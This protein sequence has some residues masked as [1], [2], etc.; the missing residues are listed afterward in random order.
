MPQSVTPRAVHAPDRTA[1]E[2]AREPTAA[3]KPSNKQPAYEQTAISAAG[4][5]I[6]GPGTRVEYVDQS[7]RW[8]RKHESYGVLVS[9]GRTCVTWKPG[10]SGRGR[11]LRTPLHEMRV[12]FCGHE[13]ADIDPRH[14]SSYRHWS[15]WTLA[16]HLQFR[17]RGAQPTGEQTAS[18]PQGTPAPAQE[19][20]Q[21]TLFAVEPENAPHGLQE[22][23]TGPLVVIPCSA[24]KLDRPA[25]AGELYTGSYHAA[26]R[27]AADAL[28]A[29]GGTVLIL[30]ARHGLLRL[31]DM[32]APYNTRMGEPGSITAAEL[33]AQARRMGIADADT[34]T[35]LAGAAYAAA[36]QA[37]WP[38]AAT[39]LAGTRG[40]GQQRARLAALARTQ[41]STAA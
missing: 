17:R 1:V 25:P 11:T 27:R 20:E 38:N 12:D 14:P 7:R 34:V 28:T 13:V 37:V 16:E 9:I 29:A 31:D 6:I 10:R 5:G 4:P 8:R 41:F 35:I 26:C 2:P 19:A 24:G 18:S 36:A 40:I 33:R 23:P 30:S 39:P 21:L 22:A 15:R 3:A 32:T